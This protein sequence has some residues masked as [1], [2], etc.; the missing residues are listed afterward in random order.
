MFGTRDEFTYFECKDCGALHLVDVPPDLGRYY[1][2]NYYSFHAGEVKLSRKLF[3]RAHLAAPKLMA[4][5]RPCRREI[6]A[7]TRI[8]PKKRA[9]ILDVGCGSGY[10]VSALRA[11]GFDAH[12][13]DAFIP[14]ERERRHIRKMTLDQVTDKWDLIVFYH[15]MEHMADHAG[16][17]RTIAD[18]LAPG[19]V[20]ITL[21]PVVGWA[22]RTYKTNWIHL[23]PPRHLV[24]HSRKSFAEISRQAGLEIFDEVHHSDEVTISY[25]E[26]YS[27]DIAVCQAR[28][29]MFTSRQIR[30]FRN[31]TAQHNA[32]KDGDV[33]A[34]YL[35][36][37][38]R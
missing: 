36:A 1:P 26:L 20:C 25:S 8:V 21:M 10:I 32:Q 33:A 31:L 2:E 23:D 16:L 19:G 34:F 9:R 28:P 3:F 13:I 5:L 38:N 4:R 7:I 15:S 14:L 29:D 11:I 12:G 18:R 24:V 35:R 27:R 22:W 37:A 6:A 30:E 17:L